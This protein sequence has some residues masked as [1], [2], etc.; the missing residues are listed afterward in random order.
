MIPYILK[1]WEY[2]HFCQ[3]AYEEELRRQFPEYSGI[4]WFACLCMAIQSVLGLSDSEVRQR[5]HDATFGVGRDESQ[6][7]I[8]Q[9]EQDGKDVEPFHR[10]DQYT[11]ASLESGSVSNKFASDYP[12]QF[13]EFVST[14]L[15]VRGGLPVQVA[16]YLIADLDGESLFRWINDRNAEG[17]ALII[18]AKVYRGDGGG[19][20]HVVFV[21]GFTNGPDGQVAMIVSDPNV[22]QP[23]LASQEHFGWFRNRGLEYGDGGI[24]IGDL[25]F[26]IRA[27]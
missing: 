24:R 5:V 6:R 3:A 10:H 9:M 13:G 15:Q 1:A 26:T 20:G 17:E 2:T 8:C 14:L 7:I 4:C 11:F 21:G 19:S 18:G 16:V 27:L 22:Y 23:I 12:E 25:L